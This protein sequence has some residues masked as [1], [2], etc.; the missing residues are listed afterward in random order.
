[1]LAFLEIAYLARNIFYIGNQLHFHLDKLQKLVYFSSGENM[2]NVLK[3]LFPFY[4][5]KQGHI[6]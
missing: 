4:Y 1:M 5:V 2:Q 3:P 6:F